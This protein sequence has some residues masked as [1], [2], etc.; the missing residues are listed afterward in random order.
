MDDLLYI[1]ARG[2]IALLQS[3]PLTWVARIGR[4][5]GALA[6]CLDARHRRVALENLTMCF[7]KEKSAAEIRAIAR[8]NYRRIGETYCCAVKT[9]AMTFEQLRP[10]A[11]YIGAE[12]LLPPR[13]V[14]N[15]GGHFGNFELYSRFKDLAPMYQ[16]A[17]TYRALNSPALNRIMQM[18]RE[19]SGCLLFERRTDGAKLRAF[20]QQPACI[21]SLQI[22]QHGGAKGLRLPF[23]GHDCSTNPSPAIFALR[24]QCELYA[25]ACFRTGLAKWR[26]E[27]GG[28]IP[29]HDENGRP[30]P[31]KDIMRDVLRIQEN[32]V[33]RDP[34]NWFWVHKRW[35]P[36]ETQAKIR[37]KTTSDS[38]A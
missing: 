27:L 23:L 6:Y 26:L 16:C 1:F 30:R 12:R 28:K 32:H 33:R 19:R 13:R 29:T 36:S 15:A 35:K 3:L 4:V 2:V 5:G 17:A 20:M 21:V 8:E 9:S 10:H 38:E 7:G 11:E 14:V 25:G 34:A 37:Q 24:Y 18:L 31:V 22:D